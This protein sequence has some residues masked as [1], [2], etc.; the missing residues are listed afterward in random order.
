M[1]VLSRSVLCTVMSVALLMSVSLFSAAAI[2]GGDITRVAESSE[3]VP[4]SGTLPENPFAPLPAEASYE[5]G[6]GENPAFVV[7]VENRGEEDPAHIIPRSSYQDGAVTARVYNAEG[8]FSARYLGWGVFSDTQGLW[9]DDAVLYLSARGVVQGVTNP[10]LTD[11]VMTAQFAPEKSVTRAE[12]VT[13]LLRLLDAAPARGDDRAFADAE[14]IPEWAREA[15]ADAA[16]LG[17][18]Q[19]DARGNANPNDTITRQDMAVMTYRAMEK[20]EMLPDVFT[21]EFL[22][23]DDWDDVADYAASPLQNLAKMKLLNGTDGRI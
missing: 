15:F 3:I 12:F 21:L 23:F 8:E 16:A 20:F 4:I 9:M 17:I 22:L 6:E 5:L 1:R 14:T 7:L 19:G 10:E 13:M 2:V 11:G 18:V